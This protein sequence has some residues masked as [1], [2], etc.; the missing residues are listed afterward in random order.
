M[1]DSEIAY[2][3]REGKT[4][5]KKNKSKELFRILYCTTDNNKRKTESS[6]YTVSWS[7]VKERSIFAKR[8]MLIHSKYKVC[9]GHT[10]LI[11]RVRL[12]PGGHVLLICI[13][14]GITMTLLT[15]LTLSSRTDSSVRQSSVYEWIGMDPHPGVF[16]GMIAWW[17]KKG[18]TSQ[19]KGNVICMYPL[20]CRRYQ[21][22]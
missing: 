19:Q 20:S 10:V 2:W 4:K 17:C 11:V 15:L 14:R 16:Q 8:D 6:Q 9:D 12:T 1:C 3:C 5:G 21:A 22:F 7:N 18:G 13:Q